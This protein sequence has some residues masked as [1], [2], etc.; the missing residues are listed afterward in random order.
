M[1]NKVKLDEQYI[2]QTNSVTQATLVA[3][4]RLKNPENILK[5]NDDVQTDAMLKAIASLNRC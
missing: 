5:T 2:G 1:I 3:N 4:A